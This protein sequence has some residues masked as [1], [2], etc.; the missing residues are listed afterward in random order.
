MKSK[1]QDAFRSYR[2]V[3]D[4]VEYSKWAIEKLFKEELNE[5]NNENCGIILKNWDVITIMKII[6]DFHRY[7]NT[8]LRSREYFDLNENSEIIKKYTNNPTEA[9]ELLWKLENVIST[10]PEL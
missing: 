8:R 5:W 7:M 3:V 1:Y 10:K 4:S 6:N 2:S 9:E